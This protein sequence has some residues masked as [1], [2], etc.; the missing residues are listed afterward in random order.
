MLDQIKAKIDRK[1]YEMSFVDVANL[2]PVTLTTSSTGSFQNSHD[3]TL[4]S[5]LYDCKTKTIEGKDAE[6]HNIH[7]P[8]KYIIDVNE[9]E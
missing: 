9:A 4:A 7:L 2:G 6:G 3:I 8:T 5:G 1:L